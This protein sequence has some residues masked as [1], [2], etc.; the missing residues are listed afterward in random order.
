MLFSSIVFLFYF[1]PVVFLL[2]YALSFS[3][4]LQNILL[5]IASL[6]FYAWGEPSYVFLMIGSILLNSGVGRLVQKWKGKK[7]KAALTVAIVANVAV[8]FVFKYLG[9][10]LK[11]F[12]ITDTSVSNLPLPIGISFFTFQALSYVVDVYRGRT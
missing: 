1:L 3:R 6:V 9:F 12:G 2:Y 7:Q 10:V 11:N 4:M 8:L 5:L